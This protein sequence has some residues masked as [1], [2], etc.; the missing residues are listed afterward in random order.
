[1]LEGTFGTC[2]VCLLPFLENSFQVSKSEH[3][4]INFWIH[5]DDGITSTIHN[6]FSLKDN[7]SSIDPP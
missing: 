6:V 1:M 5:D 2:Q 3:L 7:P 4:G